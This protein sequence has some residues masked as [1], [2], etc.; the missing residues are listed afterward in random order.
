MKRFITAALVMLL[1]VSLTTTFA[2]DPGSAS[3]PLISLSYINNTFLPSTRSDCDARITDALGALF[4]SAEDELRGAY[5]A[6]MLQAGG[7]SGYTYAEGYTPLSLSAGRT[8]ELVTGST[9]LLTSGRASVTITNG[10]VINITR[11]VEVPSG[12]SLS[13]NERYFC[14]EDTSAVF[15]AS[16][17]SVC[18]VDGY[19]KTTGA[20]I[21]TS[22]KFLDVSS[23]DW[24]YD[25]VAFA[26]DNGLFTG[27]T[28]TTFSPQSSMTRGMF[29]TVLY[30]LA[31][32]PAVSSASVFPDVS[33]KSQYYYDA[34]VWANANNIVNGYDDGRFKPDNLITREQMAVIMYRYA[35]YG[36]YGVG[37]VDTSKYDSFPDAG[38][39]SDFAA[40]AMK[41]ST[42]N[43]LINGS[44]GKLLPRNTATRAQV[45]QI[46]LNFCRNIIGM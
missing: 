31:G 2:T 6:Y 38:S 45:A 10:T 12:T 41:W 34:V 25:A 9:F 24:F 16:S 7:Y 27:T 11:G 5:D 18:Q 44:D 33:A 19:Y 8:A 32:K 14:A 36:G 46:V 1:L 30:R 20:V 3:D 39:V 22:N 21:V 13:V 29:V 4:D 15:M 37:A 42:S 17:D 35:S 23:A 28:E 26:G 43:G 40:D